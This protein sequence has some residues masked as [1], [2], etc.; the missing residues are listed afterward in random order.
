MRP[1]GSSSVL[2]SIRNFHCQ[3]EGQFSIFVSLLRIAC[4]VIFLSYL[5][6]EVL[7]LDGSKRP[8][9][10]HRTAS[11]EVALEEVA[12]LKTALIP[13]LFKSG[14][15][16]SLVSFA[17]HGASVQS[18]MTAELEI[19][20]LGVAQRRCCRVALPRSSTSDPSFSA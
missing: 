15:D 10:S 8:L 3:R 12:G 7:D 9:K 17:L 13:Q 14:S 5:C 20:S 4:A 19:I 18:Q 16:F 1:A 11:T 6:F 2:T